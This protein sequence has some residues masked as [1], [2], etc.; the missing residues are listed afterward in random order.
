[1]KNIYQDYL[2][3][4]KVNAIAITIGTVR[5]ANKFVFS[6]KKYTLFYLF[7]YMQ[8]YFK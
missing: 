8:L 3:S 1:M 6:L 7:I 4:C 5:K 2:K